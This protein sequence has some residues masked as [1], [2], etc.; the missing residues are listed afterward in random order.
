[1]RQALEC[2]VLL[3]QKAQASGRQCLN[4]VALSMTELSALSNGKDPGRTI[5]VT[6]VG[7]GCQK[8]ERITGMCRYKSAKV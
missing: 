8:L 5:M 7:V 3:L 1:M 6:G 2:R 4:L